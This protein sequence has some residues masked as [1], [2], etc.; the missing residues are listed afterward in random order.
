[1]D[2]ERLKDLITTLAVGD[3]SRVY[4]SADGTEFFLRKPTRVGRSVKRP[5]DPSLNFVVEVREPERKRFAPNHARVFLHLDAARRLFPQN[6]DRILMAL[7]GV[8]AHEDPV[9]TSSDLRGLIVEPYGRSLDYDLFLHQLFLAEQELVYPGKSAFDPKSL[10]YQGWVRCVMCGFE[11]I[12]KI[13]WSSLRGA[14]RA[15][16]TQLD[17]RK[18]RKH[19]PAA[20]PLWYLEAARAYFQKRS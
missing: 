9:P 19:D 3:E 10:Y 15:I 11:E 13:L 18:S 8:F 5:S 7:D 14:P 6:R 16:Y 20:K 2:F 4:E 17:N 12:D 1:M